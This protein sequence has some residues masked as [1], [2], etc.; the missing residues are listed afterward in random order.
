MPRWGCAVVVMYRVHPT[1]HAILWSFPF[2]FPD[3]HHLKPKE[4]GPRAR[5]ALLLPL[6]L[7]PSSTHGKCWWPLLKRSEQWPAFATGAGARAASCP[8]YR[9]S[10]CSSLGFPFRRRTHRTCHA[11]QVNKTPNNLKPSE[12]S[13]SQLEFRAELRPPAVSTRQPS[14]AG[15]REGDR[16]SARVVEEVTV[17]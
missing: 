2:S 4:K 10:P 3:G 6:A 17:D 9:S 16:D 11:M 1:L 15:G 8:V 13:E 5:A 7:A 14:G 12:E